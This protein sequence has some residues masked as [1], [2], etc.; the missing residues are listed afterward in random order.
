[1]DKNSAIG[2]TLIAGLLLIY[3]TYFGPTPETVKPIPSQVETRDSINSG[4]ASAA[5]SY[6][7]DQIKRD[8]A[9][10]QQYG[11]LSSLLSGEEKTTYVETADLAIKFSNH[12]AIIKE[13]ELRN[14]KTYY[15]NPL[16]LVSEA[17]N[18]F[19][20]ITAYEGKDVDL[21]K[22]YYSADLR[23]AG[24]TTI[25]IFTSKISDN[26][27]IAVIGP[28]GGDLEVIDIAVGHIGRRA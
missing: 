3:F 18:T 23:K 6:N 2:L 22:L 19:S 16:L 20:L 14:F 9:L 17:N 10:I 5:L 1:M 13:L 24:D 28:L 27:F 4:T 26:A 12:G 25:L 11:N 8:S 21:A 7:R 15:K